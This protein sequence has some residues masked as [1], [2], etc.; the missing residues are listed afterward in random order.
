MYNYIAMYGKYEHNSLICH[1]YS[2][3][4]LG[5]YYAWSSISWLMRQSNASRMPDIGSSGLGVYSLGHLVSVN[6]TTFRA[7][8]HALTPSPYKHMFTANTW[9]HGIQ[10]LRKG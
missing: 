1:S 4:G 2:K 5:E 10:K 8:Q 7:S 3:S 6:A 9:Q